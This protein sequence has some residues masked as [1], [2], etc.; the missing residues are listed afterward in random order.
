MSETNELMD[1]EETLKKELRF[2]L[3]FEHI[4]WDYFIDTA[5]EAKREQRKEK[6]KQKER[7]FRK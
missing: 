4:D 2:Q 7:M 5:K 3:S 1:K 6:L